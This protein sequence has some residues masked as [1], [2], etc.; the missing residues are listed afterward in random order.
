MNNIGY[1]NLIK[2][3]ARILEDGSAEL[4]R[5]S[6]RVP[7]RLIQRIMS[8]NGSYCNKIYDDG[9]CVKTT[10]KTV[11]DKDR[12]ILDTWDSVK[13]RGINVSTVKLE[14][15]SFISRAFDKKQ[16]G[17]TLQDG[18]IYLV[19]QGD[20]TRYQTEIKALSPTHSV[21]KPFCSLGWLNDKFSSLFNKGKSI[22]GRFTLK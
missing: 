15:R 14:G 9:N 2:S 22:F 17:S 5:K 4:W 6:E 3:G 12:Y 20:R 13:S 21:A 1:E 8:P 7:N 18:L 11:L 16:D 19:R 10:R